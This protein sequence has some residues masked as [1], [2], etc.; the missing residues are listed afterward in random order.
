M[1]EIKVTRIGVAS[2]AGVVGA[3]AWG[4]SLAFGWPLLVLEDIIPGMGLG[5]F[6][7]SVAGA[8]VGGVVAGAATAVLY[9]LVA[10][11]TGG[12]RLEVERTAHV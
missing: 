12:V 3:I 11:F 5:L 6:A 8:T 10:R 4:M 1:T 9:N 2:L 7:V